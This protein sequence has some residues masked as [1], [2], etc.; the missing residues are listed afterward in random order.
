MP[1]NEKIIAVWGSPHAGKTAFAVK[2]AENL[3]QR[4]RGAVVVLHCDLL[5]PTLPILFPNA[6]EQDLFSV[7]TVLAKPNIFRG[8]IVSNL[9]TVKERQNLGFLGYRTGENRYSFPTFGRVKV[10]EFFAVLSDLADSIV[11][12]HLRPRKQ[13]VD[14]GVLAGCRNADSSIVPRSFL[15]VLLSVADGGRI[16]NAEGAHGQH[17]ECTGAGH[18]TACLGFCLPPRR[19]GD[20]AVQRSP[21]GTESGRDADS[22]DEGQ[23]VSFRY[24]KGDRGGDPVKEMELYPL[25]QLAQGYLS[26]HYAQALVDRSKGAE[27]RAYIA[28]YL[29]DTGYTVAGFTRESLTDRLYAEMAEYSVLTP[30]LKNP[31]IEEINVNGWDDIALT[32]LDGRIE[33]LT[34][35]F[36]SPGHAVDVIK[37]LLHHSGMIIDSARPMSQGHLPGNTRIT[38]LMDP[39]VD[40]ERRIAASIRMLHPQRVDRESLL[41]T[42]SIT[43]EMLSFLEMCLRFGVS[44]VV[45]GRTSSGK[46]TLLN[47]LLNSVPDSKRIYTIE[48]GARELSLLKRDAEGRVINNVVHTLSRPSENPNSDISQEDLVMAALRFDPDVICVGEMRDAEAHS[49]VEASSTDH[50]VVT[51]VHGGGGI[52][53]HQR[54]AFLS[55]RRFP[56]AFDISMRQ[57][58]QAFPVVVFAHKLE[59]NSRKVMDISECVVGE[60]GGLT[61]RT[62]YKYH[63]TDNRFADG[64]FR[65]EGEFRKENTPS[66]SLCAKLMRGGVPQETLQRFMKGGGA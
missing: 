46:T 7:G 56:I 35:H 62:L 14:G 2:F 11:G 29:Y 58:A 61:Y 42:Q 33:K 32:H 37:K 20:S 12:L 40:G 31:D 45:A 27:L 30:W 60:D 59:D 22:A 1:T 36:F 21:A 19:T 4:T 57:A 50:T 55:Q 6:R 41:R 25:L 64:A 26:A 51:T 53:A 39:I 65:M 48:S 43:D 44:F 10:A 15:A 38:V 24:R 28:K 23:A 5:T 9:V 3:Y 52:F 63:I 18:R 34:E 49:A 47:S 66:P 17:P 13:P 54:I 8:D 16:R